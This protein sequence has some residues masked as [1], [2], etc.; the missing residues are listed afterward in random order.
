MKS[1]A[2]SFSAQQLEQL[3]ALDSPQAIQAYLDSIP[4]SP[5]DANRS[6]ASV[7]RD[8]MAHC[9]DGALFAAAALWRLGEPPL[10][11]DLLPD[12]GMDD[13]HMLAI[14]KRDGCYGALAKSNYAGL[15]FRE[16]I[17]HTLRELV[18]SYFED[19]YN[20]DGVKTLRTYTLP[21][22]LS[23]LKDIHW[24]DDDSA[25]DQIMVRLGRMR[26]IALLTPA[27]IAR[28]S[29]MDR[30]SFEAGRLGCDPDGLYIP[31]K[32]GH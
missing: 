14:F 3:S 23:T 17:H 12:P 30:R 26:H 32:S 13:D 28:L 9:L 7:L 15:R 16:A 29:P 6:P 21:L 18:L 25:P 10:V 4:Y 19:Y 5:E 20:V 31:G 1:F 8:G 2:E 27:M 22:D 11:V 24:L